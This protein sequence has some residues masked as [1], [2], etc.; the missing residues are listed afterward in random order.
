MLKSLIFIHILSAAVWTGGHLILTISFL[1][2][3][4]KK[5]DFQIIQDFEA[6]FEPIGL[7]A[8]LI[9]S[10]TGIYFATIYTPGFFEFNWLD[11][12]TRHIFLKL[13]LLITTIGLALH[14][15]LVLIP[16][17]ALRPLAWHII[18]VTIVSVLL[19]L[20]GFSTRSGG[21]L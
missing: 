17:K 4:L 16:K 10:L 13:M 19:V 14:A 5:N 8:L 12:Y 9:L 3:A 21:I 1:P 18:G 2:K 20:V 7:P 11:H 6:R 15:R